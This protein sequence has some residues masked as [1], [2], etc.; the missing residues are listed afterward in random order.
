MKQTLLGM[1]L[2]ML[3]GVALIIIFTI[4]IVLKVTRVMP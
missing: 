2:D 4:L 1:N 3:K